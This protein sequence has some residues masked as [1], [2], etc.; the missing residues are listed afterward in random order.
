MEP[1]LGPVTTG[2]KEKSGV[3]IMSDRASLDSAGPAPGRPALMG[4]LN[5]E[6]VDADGVD[7]QG[8]LIGT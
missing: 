3:I 6:P 4:A 7:A 2:I 5:D 8:G 1:F